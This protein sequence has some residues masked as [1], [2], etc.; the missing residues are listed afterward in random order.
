[1]S[2][3]SNEKEILA[4]NENKYGDMNEDDDINIENIDGEWL[5]ICQTSSKPIYKE[6]IIFETM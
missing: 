4:E 1:V 6:D 2:I 3:D 5:N